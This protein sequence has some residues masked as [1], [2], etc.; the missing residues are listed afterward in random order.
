MC[1]IAVCVG[2]WGVKILIEFSSVYFIKNY[3]M[4]HVVHEQN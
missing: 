2:G 1:K 4:V 3:E